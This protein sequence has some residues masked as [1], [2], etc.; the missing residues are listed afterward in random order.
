MS[1]EL[2]VGGKPSTFVGDEQLGYVYYNETLP[3]SRFNKLLFNYFNVLPKDVKTR[4]ERKKKV[5]EKFK[6][7]NHVYVNI[8]IH[9]NVAEIDYYC[10]E[11]D[12]REFLCKHD[13][14]FFDENPD[15]GIDLLGL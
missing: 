13:F 4:M 6:D 2:I 3:L 9:Q 5:N 11:Q 12:P 1:L 14:D 15:D 7:I 10:Y 8:N